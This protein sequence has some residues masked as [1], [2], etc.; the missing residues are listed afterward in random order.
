MLHHDHHTRVRGRCLAA[1]SSLGQRAV[2]THL[3]QVWQK[4]VLCWRRSQPKVQA[5][6]VSDGVHIYSHRVAKQRHFHARGATARCSHPTHANSTIGTPTWSVTR[7]HISPCG[8]RF[9]TQLCALHGPFDIIIDDGAHMATYIRKT[10][11][12]LF[13]SHSCMTNR[14]ARAPHNV[15][16][17]SADETPRIRPSHI[18][19][20][21]ARCV[22]DVYSM[23]ALRMAPGRPMLWRTCT[24]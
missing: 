2:P 7:I 8:T 11:A 3:V 13:P 23:R 20:G 14:Y 1:F 10:L 9:L 16:T 12:I 19:F 5:Q 15:T 4:P 24:P 22:L 17:C 6:R 21:T 18:N